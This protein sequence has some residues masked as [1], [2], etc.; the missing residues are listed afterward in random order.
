[1]KVKV[2]GALARSPCQAP[3]SW[4]LPAVAPVQPVRARIL[5]CVG[6]DE[7]GALGAVHHHAGSCVDAKDVATQPDDE[8]DL[9]RARDDRRVAHEGAARKRQAGHARRTHDRHLGWQEVIGDEHRQRAVG[10]PQAGVLA[11]GEPPPDAPAHVADIGDSSLEERVIE[12]RQQRGLPIGRRLHGRLCRRPRADL[13]QR[14]PEE[15]GVT[16]QQRLRLQDGGRVRPGDGRRRGGERLQL[17]GCR[18]C[19]HAD[20]ARL[21]IPVRRRGPGAGIERATGASI[22]H[23]QGPTDARAGRSPL[24]HQD[25]AGHAFAGQVVSVSAS[26]PSSIAVEVAPGSW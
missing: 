16:C 14:R 11:T 25:G 8:R 23:L 3:R 26:A 24:A 17:T 20:A 6:L 18:L 21:L 1:M 12:G 9:E 13:L 15:R 5:V 4:I 19:R 22:G 10:M 2:A 7:D